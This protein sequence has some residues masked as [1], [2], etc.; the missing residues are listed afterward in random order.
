MLK[1][2]KIQRNT[3]MISPLFFLSIRFFFKRI[4][5]YSMWVF[6]YAN[7]Q[8]FPV[9]YWSKSKCGK[10]DCQIFKYTGP[11]IWLY[12]GESVV[13]YVIVL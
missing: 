2:P 6:W 11:N 5:R 13:V 12:H 3:Q 9:H 7:I 4:L 1:N 8:D 10:S